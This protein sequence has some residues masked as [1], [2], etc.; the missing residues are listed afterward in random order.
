M[1]P[2]FD[3]AYQ[4]MRAKGR[5]K[6]MTDNPALFGF[7]SDH[8]SFLRLSDKDCVSFLSRIVHKIERNRPSLKKA[9]ARI[10]SECEWRQYEAFLKRIAATNEG[11]VRDLPLVRESL[12]K[13]D[14]QALA[15]MTYMRKVEESEES[16][17]SIDDIRASV[18]DH[19][20]G[21][22]SSVNRLSNLVKIP[23]C[24]FFKVHM[25]QYASLLGKLAQVYD[26]DRT[27]VYQL[28]ESKIRIPEMF[29]T[30]I[31]DAFQ[32]LGTVMK[33]GDSELPA[34]IAGDAIERIKYDAAACMSS[35][36]SDT[37]MPQVK[38][39]FA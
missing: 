31:E 9:I 12:M 22:I 19:L 5:L 38:T 1:L 4:Y 26:E 16:Q 11:R 25:L 27:R 20:Q 36:N 24:R 21:L 35:Y 17:K 18:Y 3:R 39:H 7:L 6:I 30:A 8:A 37:V 33:W 15:F 23:D 28:G 29:D 2:L 14:D 34:H 32:E 13:W 10:L